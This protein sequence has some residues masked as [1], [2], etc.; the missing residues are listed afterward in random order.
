VSGNPAGRPRGARG[1]LSEDFLAD[2]HAA[3]NEHG[4]TALQRC[5]LEEPAQFCRIVANLLPRDLDINLTATVDVADF[6]TRFRTAVEL[7]GN[8][9]PRL[10]KPPPRTIE[11][12]D[13]G[14]R[15]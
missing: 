7:L 4:T 8:T 13:V 3:W 11:A 12:K 2:L 14:N 15:R 6:A 1:K 10:S 9:P 5:A